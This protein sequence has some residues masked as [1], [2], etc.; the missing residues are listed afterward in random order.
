MHKIVTIDITT[1]KKRRCI[2]YLKERVSFPYS[3][4]GIQDLLQRHQC[5][6]IAIAQ[7]Q[8][9]DPKRGTYTLYSLAFIVKGER[10]LIEFPVIF[11]KN[12]KGTQL[13]MDIAGRIIFYKVK[14]LLT[15]V[16]IGY[17]DFKEAML[18][19]RVVTLPDG[20]QCTLAD[21][22][23]K[24]GPELSA[25]TADLLALPGGGR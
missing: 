15:D 2:P 20:S 25:G 24:H 11:A 14:A 8:I 23:A 9:T 19:F 10:F 6:Q 21:Y 17:L 12:T 5:D 7:R 22:V 16:E 3:L 18:A 4:Q 1:E 13:R